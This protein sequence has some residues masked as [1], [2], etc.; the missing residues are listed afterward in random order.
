VSKPEKRMEESV[1]EKD[2]QSYKIVSNE[3]ERV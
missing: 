3:W 1:D 2:G